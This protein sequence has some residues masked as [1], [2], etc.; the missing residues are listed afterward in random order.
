[1]GFQVTRANNA[2]NEIGI[3]VNIRNREGKRINSFPAV[4]ANLPPFGQGDYKPGA[5][6]VSDM[7]KEC[8]CKATSSYP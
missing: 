6:K 7:H 5:R 1:M 2:A 4:D 8:L 3:Y